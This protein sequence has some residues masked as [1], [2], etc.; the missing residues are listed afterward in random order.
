MNANIVE[1][2]ITNIQQILFYETKRTIMQEIDTKYLL[3]KGL[4]HDDNVFKELYSTHNIETECI[5]SSDQ[6][7][8]ISKFT[9][10]PSAQKIREEKEKVIKQ[11]EKANNIKILK[12]E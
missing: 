2:L 7:V 12:W 6:G 10:K 1:K 11:F 4:E 3:E 9:K 8:A 5:G